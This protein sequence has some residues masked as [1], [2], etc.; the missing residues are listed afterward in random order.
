MIIVRK[1]TLSVYSQFKGPN[2]TKEGYVRLPDNVSEVNHYLCHI[3]NRT[4]PMCYQCIPGF[5]PSLTSVPFLCTNCTRSA[6]YGALL[7]I[8][9]EFVPIT[10]FFLFIL[11]F[12]IHITSAPMTCFIAY[13]QT[14]FILCAYNHT[15]EKIN[16]IASAI[17]TGI[18]HTG[19]VVYSAIN[20]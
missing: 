15:D 14:V 9:V 13:S 1:G 20:L 5:G 2:V 7:Y 4:G 12:R 11:S 8:V 10:V 19:L 16:F 3:L 6:R 18:M 17:D